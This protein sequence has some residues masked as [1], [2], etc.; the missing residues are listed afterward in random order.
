[1]NQAVLCSGNA[2]LWVKDMGEASSL[3]FSFLA[4]VQF[5]R[6]GYMDVFRFIAKSIP[7]HGSYSVTPNRKMRVH[8]RDLSPAVSSHFTSN[9]LRAS[10]FLYG[11]ERRQK[12]WIFTALLP[13]VKRIQCQRLQNLYEAAPLIKKISLLLLLLVLNRIQSVPYA[14]KHIY[15]RK[16][17]NVE[18]TH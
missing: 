18:I 5:Q 14:I 2:A 15:F 12:D 11:R 8:P 16:S 3:L 13:L 9:L 7:L 1:M 6:V 10:I 4:T 17:F